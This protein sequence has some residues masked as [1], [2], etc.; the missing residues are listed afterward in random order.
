MATR[1]KG[2][3]GSLV[4]PHQSAFI[5][6]RLIQDSIFIANEIFHHLKGKKRGRIPD[7]A[8]KMDISKAYDRV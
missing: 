1:L 6:N 3:L 7:L 2:I 5:P 8:I 4:T